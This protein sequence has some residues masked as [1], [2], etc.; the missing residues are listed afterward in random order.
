MS[1]L[2]PG[3]SILNDYCIRHNMYVY[4]TLPPRGRNLKII[5]G[6]YIF[7]WYLNR[8]CCIKCAAEFQRQDPNFGERIGHLAGDAVDNLGKTYDDWQ[9]SICYN[10]GL[11]IPPH[12]RR[13]SPD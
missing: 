4:Q 6:L 8:T 7:R 9:R 13:S 10:E 3:K 2:F 12:L 1:S 5:T 11:P